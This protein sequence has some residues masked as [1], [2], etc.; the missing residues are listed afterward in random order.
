MRK[1]VTR[2]HWVAVCRPEGMASSIA[3]LT[4]R[5]RTGISASTFDGTNINETRMRL[6]PWAGPL[7]LALLGPLAGAAQT[8]PRCA[9]LGALSHSLEGV[10]SRIAPAVV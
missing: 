9:A 10:V 8:P 5:W 3:T 4:E 1:K 2:R 7:A 6:F